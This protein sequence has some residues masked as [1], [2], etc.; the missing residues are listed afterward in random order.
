MIYLAAG[1]CCPSS[2]SLT[3]VS[4]GAYFSS[5]PFDFELEAIEEFTA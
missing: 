4:S 1:I 5:T 3:T 2:S